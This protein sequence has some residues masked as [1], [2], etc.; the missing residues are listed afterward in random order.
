[1]YKYTT[2]GTIRV[3]REPIWWEVFTI[4]VSGEIII[5]DML[6]IRKSYNSETK[7]FRDGQ[8]IK[9]FYKVIQIA[10]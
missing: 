8:R 1:M 9:Y 2:K 3:E 4:H 7:T 10:A 5:G 6:H